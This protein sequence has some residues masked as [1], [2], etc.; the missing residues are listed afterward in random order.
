MTIKLRAMWQKFYLVKQMYDLIKIPNEKYTKYRSN[1]TNVMA[2]FLLCKIICIELIIHFQLKW[3]N[4]HRTFL[5][6]H[7][8]DVRL[9]QML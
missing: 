9:Y 8:V 3:M 6:A 1:K 7:N 5:K 4:I 2:L